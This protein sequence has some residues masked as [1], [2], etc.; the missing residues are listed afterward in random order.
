MLRPTTQQSQPSLCQVARDGEQAPRLDAERVTAATWIR[1]TMPTTAAGVT[2]TATWRRLA[3][4][5]RM[6]AGIGA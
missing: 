6:P 1:A 2:P 5:A 4:C 3:D